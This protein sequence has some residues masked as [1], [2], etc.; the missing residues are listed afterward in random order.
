MRT[1]S[2]VIY[3]GPDSG[4]V[5]HLVHGY[6]GAVDRVNAGVVSFLLRHTTTE[7]RPYKG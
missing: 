4:N 6:N 5:F 3:V 7:E 2:F 1:S